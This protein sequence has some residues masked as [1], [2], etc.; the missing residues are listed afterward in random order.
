MNFK[1]FAKIDNISFMK[2][3]IWSKYD[4][5]YGLKITPPFTLHSMLSPKASRANRMPA[6]GIRGG[7]YRVFP[8]VGGILSGQF[9]H[10]RPGYP[11]AGVAA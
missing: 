9:V 4:L 3:S 10:S 6:P 5:F 7:M 8:V 1:L 2:Y 11:Q